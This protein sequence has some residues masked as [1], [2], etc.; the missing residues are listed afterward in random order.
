ML[1]T[2]ITNRKIEN[3]EITYGRMINRKKAKRSIDYLTKGILMT[4]AI[5]HLILKRIG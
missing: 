3:A 2:R 5:L 4:M 1:M